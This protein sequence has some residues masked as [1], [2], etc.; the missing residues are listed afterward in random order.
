VLDWDLAKKLVPRV[1]D[2]AELDSMTKFI[3]HVNNLP[4][5]STAE[6]V[7]GPGSDLFLDKEIMEAIDS[8]GPVSDEAFARVQAKIAHIKGSA[9]ECNVPDVRIRE[10]IVPLASIA[11]TKGECAAAHYPVVYD[12]SHK[13]YNLWPEKPASETGMKQ[14]GEP[15]L[16]TTLGK[17]LAAKT[18]EQDTGLC[19][20]GT[21][22]QRTK[23]GLEM[24][25][26]RD[27][28]RAAITGRKEDGSPDLRTIRGRQIAAE[29]E[30][31]AMR[32]LAAQAASANQQRDARQ[33]Q[34]DVQQQKPV[35]RAAATGLC[36]DGVT[37]D[38]RTTQGKEMLRSMPQSTQ[39]QP[40]LVLA[41]TGSGA[42]ASHGGR[43]AATGFRL[44]GV[45]PDLR[46]T[47]G[48]AMAC[49][50][51]TYGGGSGLGGGTF[52]STYRYA[53]T[54]SLASFGGSAHHQWNGNAAGP[55]TKSGMPDM[56]YRANRA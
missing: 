23:P 27:D 30:A 24:G 56:R 38:L 4:I 47:L 25:V 52:M 15:D 16:R 37:P 22:S 7:E 32:K 49:G 3:N 11:N 17:Q 14:D 20:D 40:R 35:S 6:N 33:Q 18:F 55:V 45:S 8:H 36:K 19:L 9:K 50:S 29:I 1:T 21:V 46:T 26:R 10:M 12:G 2:Q 51:M 53:P 31:R 28:T 42:S 48:R 34:R 13:P 39:S 44:D 41:H 43:A 54:S 5:K